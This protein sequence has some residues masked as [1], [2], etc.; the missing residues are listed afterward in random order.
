MNPS[1]LEFIEMNRIPD[2]GFFR[3]SQIIGDR[4]KDIPAI[5]PV[6]SS[7]WWAGVQSGRY[8]RPIK[9]YGTTLW[10][11]RDIRELVVQIG[12]DAA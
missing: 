12:G 5:I 10:R 8:P 7:T 9:H 11:V 6:S 2:T 1:S 4:R 3:L